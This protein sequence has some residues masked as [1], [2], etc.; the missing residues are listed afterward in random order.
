[1]SSYQGRRTFDKYP[2][3]HNQLSADNPFRY[4]GTSYNPY[5]PKV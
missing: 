5:M 2:Y 4:M 3:S 1:M